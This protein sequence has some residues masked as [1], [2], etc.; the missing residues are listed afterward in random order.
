MKKLHESITKFF[1][2]PTRDKFRELVQF[3]TGEYDNLDFK[4]K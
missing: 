2:D 1:E 3:N 4:K